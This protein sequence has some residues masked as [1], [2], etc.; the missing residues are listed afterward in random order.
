M[1]VRHQRTENDGV[2]FITIT[3]AQWL[4]LFQI[5]NS[6]HVVYKWFDVLVSK[7]HYIVGYVIM[8]NHIHALIAFR[9]TN[10]SINTIVANG[11]RFMAYDI[12][13]LLKQQNQT[14]ILSRLTSLVNHTDRKRGKLHEVFEPSFDCKE[15]TTAKFVEQKLNYIH[16]NPCRYKPQLVNLPQ[17]YLHSSARFYITGEQGYYPVTSYMQLLDI[18][19]TKEL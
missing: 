11:K 5:T 3:N 10:Q 16:S 6:Y 7:G 9:K 14:T 17:D 15:C 4:P 8:P 2:Y 19:L 1:S 18:D 12:V 13:E